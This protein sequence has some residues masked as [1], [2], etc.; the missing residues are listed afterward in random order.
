MIANVYGTVGHEDKIAECEANAH[1][2]SA[3][4]ELLAALQ[5]TLGLVELHA[6]AFEYVGTVGRARQAIA[7]A[8]GEEVLL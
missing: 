7:K 6:G 3:A 1:L 2:I 8:K 5:E 4:T